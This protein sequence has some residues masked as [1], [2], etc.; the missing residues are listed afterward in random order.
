M[1]KKFSRLYDRASRPERRLSLDFNQ[2][3][4]AIF[5][6]HHK[7]DGSG[8][9]DFKKNAPLYDAALSFYQEHRFQLIVLGDNEELWENSYQQVHSQHSAVIAR[10]ISMAPMGVDQKRIRIWGNHDKEVSLRSFVRT[11]RKQKIQILDAVDYR[12]S[13]CLGQDIFLVHGHQGRFFE[14]KAW[15]ISRWAV[16][17]VWK[18]IQKILHIGIDG[19]A[20]NFR[21][22]EDLER[23]YYNWGK[24]HKVL[25]VC[26]HTHQAIFGSLTHFDR[27]QI[28]V[29]ELGKRQKDAPPEEK[30]KIQQEIEAK[31][32][33]IAGILFRR[34]GI[35]PKSFEKP[36]SRAVPCYFN[37]GCCGYTNGITCIEIDQGQIRLIKWE[38][39]TTSRKILVEENLEHIIQNVRT[40][41]PFRLKS[42]TH[43]AHYPVQ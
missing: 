14:D 9:D 30:D 3:R 40:Q 37:S 1:E 20:E 18:T 25:L 31:E 42:Q 12:E 32:K 16:Q 43:I 11:I 7:G 28:S 35:P 36:A 17:L 5:S 29:T 8:A 23:K 4:Y 2:D 10:E 33:I 39:E 13:L 38:R 6:D 24:A 27:L 26:G 34:M 15:K 22:R 19:P 41:K 21:L